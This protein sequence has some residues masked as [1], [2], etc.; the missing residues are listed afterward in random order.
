MNASKFVQN[1]RRPEEQTNYPYF[2][3]YYVNDLFPIVTFFSAVLFTS[4][5]PDNFPRKLKKKVKLLIQIML[6]TF[7][8]PRPNDPNVYGDWPWTNGGNTIGGSHNNGNSGWGYPHNNGYYGKG[9]IGKCIH[10]SIILM[11][12][13][14]RYVVVDGFSIHN[15]GVFLPQYNADFFLLLECGGSLWSFVWDELFRHHPLLPYV[16][17]PLPPPSLACPYIHSLD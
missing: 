16:A 6:I 5:Q 3:L 9:D 10:W 14:S 1:A 4:T 8:A 17:S 12:S 2:I 7:A 13:L 15:Q 11:V